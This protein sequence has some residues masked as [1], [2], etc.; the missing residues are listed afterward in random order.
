MRAQS[1]P[2]AE[3]LIV[4]FTQVFGLNHLIADPSGRAE[5]IES[6]RA[7][8]AIRRMGENGEKGYLIATNHY[9]NQSMKSSQPVWDPLE[10][11]PSSHY[12]Y[13]TAEKQIAAAERGLNYTGVRDILA[14]TDWW[15][16]KEWH[17]DDPWSGN[18]INRFEKDIVT[19]YSLIAVPADCVVS[20]C[21][22]NPGTPYLGTLS[23]GETGSYVNYS[24]GDSPEDMVQ[25]LKSDAR[26]AMRRTGLL[27]TSHSLERVIDQW[28]HAEDNYSEGVWWLD[29][30][31]SEDDR[32]A[33]AVAL[34]RSATAFSMVLATVGE[35]QRTSRDE[36]ES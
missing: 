10:Y 6:T 36:R 27:I 19:L 12:R 8:H 30:A 22:G 23:S 34:G 4:N 2:E 7:R 32:T 9:M 25:E 15:D 26:T 33:R 17:Y 31:I 24:L 28:A 21:S 5:V 11:Y 35:I 18:S 20:I 3:G 14:L 13:I 1:V 29:R 16:G